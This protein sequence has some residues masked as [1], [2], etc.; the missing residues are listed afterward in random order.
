MSGS[1]VCSALDKSPVRRFALIFVAVL[2]LF[3]PAQVQVLAATDQKKSLVFATWEDF[4]ADKCASIWLIRRFVAPSAMIRFFPKGE[5][6]QEGIPFD[7]PDAELRRYHNRSTFETLLAH[8][9]LSDQKLVLLGKIIHDIEVNTWERKAFAESYQIQGDV[10]QII[11]DSKHPD[12]IASQCQQYF[13]L[14]YER[15]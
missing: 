2:Y 8:Y 9:H 10:R 14:W 3:Y 11:S 13:D 6:I 4:E 1:N 15:A 12:G 7:T 5:V